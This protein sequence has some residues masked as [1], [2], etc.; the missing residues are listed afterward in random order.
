MISSG[1]TL[2][3]EFRPAVLQTPRSLRRYAPPICA[4][5]PILLLPHAL[6]SPSP[7]QPEKIKHLL[8]N[9]EAGTGKGSVMEKVEGMKYI[10]AVRWVIRVCLES[11]CPRSP[12]PP[13]RPHQQQM[14]RGSDASGFYPDVVRNVIVRASKDRG[15]VGGGE[16]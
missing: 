6:L 1:V 2:G 16:F 13:F 4:P 15:D 9:I 8:D 12:P 3:G 7:P 5:S 10:L 14:A 11:A